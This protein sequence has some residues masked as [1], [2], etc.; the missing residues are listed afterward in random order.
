M[1]QRNLRPF[2]LDS[3]PDLDAVEQAAYEAGL[4]VRADAESRSAGWIDRTVEVALNTN[5]GFPRGEARIALQ[6]GPADEVVAALI[7]GAAFAEQAD[8]AAVDDAIAPS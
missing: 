4:A 1:T 5:H 2:E 7:A 6:L 8:A 3:I